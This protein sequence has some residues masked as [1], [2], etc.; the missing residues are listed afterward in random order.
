MS[1]VIPQIVQKYDLLK[2]TFPKNSI[3]CFLSSTMWVVPKESACFKNW[4]EPENDKDKNITSKLVQKDCF[5][6]TPL[7][8]KYF[9]CLHPF[10]AHLII[11]PNFYQIKFVNPHNQKIW[12]SSSITRGISCWPKIEVILQCE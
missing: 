4:A 7:P 8:L 9:Q 2:T 1:I 5:I 3:V 11:F 12:V 6:D 10:L